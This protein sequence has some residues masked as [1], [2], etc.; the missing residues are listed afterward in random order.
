M[1]D[2]WKR[3]LQTRYDMK[4][5]TE[6]TMAGRNQKKKRRHSAGVLP[7]LLTMAAVVAAVVLCVAIFFKVGTITVT[8]ASHYTTAEII[9]ASGV[10]QGDNMLLVDRSEASAR[11][12]AK[13]PYITGAQVSRV[14]PE[15]VNITVTECEAA[16]CAADAYGAYWLIAP[17]ARVLE[18]TDEEPGVPVLTGLTLAD[19]QPGSLLSTLEEDAADGETV[20]AVLT[21]LADSTVAEHIVSIDFEKVYSI[22]MMYGEQ[23]EVDLGGTDELAYKLQYLE[24]ILV[25]LAAREPDAAGQI[26]LTLQTEKVA[27]FLPW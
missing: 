15:T 5:M 25:E 20:A 1:R 14:L 17:D 11:I 12:L 6:D 4:G 10:T 13:L 18:R 21:A 3:T 24:Q 23:Y 9:A 27:R 7:G 22:R 26:D 16:A 8:G 19:P 2:G